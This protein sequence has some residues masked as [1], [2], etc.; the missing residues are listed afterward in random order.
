[1]VSS[2][3]LFF[4]YQDDAWSNTHQKRDFIPGGGC[5][6]GHEVDHSPTSSAE[7]KNEWQNTY[8]DSYAFMVFKGTTLFFM[9]QH[10]ALQSHVSLFITP[11][12]LCCLYCL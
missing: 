5:W 12:Y 10:G 2:W 11:E 9:K 6:P 4:S 3:I 1:V 7:V 8:A